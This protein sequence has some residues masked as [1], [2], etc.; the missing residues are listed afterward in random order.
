MFKLLTCKKIQFYKE[1]N[2]TIA[3]ILTPDVVNAL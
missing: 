2:R 3:S 1:E